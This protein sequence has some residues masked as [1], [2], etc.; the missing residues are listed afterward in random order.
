MIENTCK[1]CGGKN[2]KLIHEGTRDRADINVLK[3]S[4]CGFVFLSKVVV[5]DA[6]YSDSFMRKNIDFVNWRKNTY[7]DDNRRY[8][9]YKNL[10]SGKKI[11][12]FGCGNG[13]F[14]TL[15]KEKKMQIGSVE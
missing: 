13:G 9:Q 2:I 8:S 5:D 15:A 7:T 3:C 12:D 4:E 1:L 10:I 6:F 14:L 11:L